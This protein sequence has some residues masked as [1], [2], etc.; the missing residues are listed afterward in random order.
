MKHI[1]KLIIGISWFLSGI[2]L[3]D[4]FVLHGKLKLIWIALAN[5]SDYSP[6][7]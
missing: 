3:F 5:T 6:F 4:M 7:K 1:L 2:V